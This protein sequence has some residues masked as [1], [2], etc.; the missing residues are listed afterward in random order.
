MNNL[1]IQ[2]IFVRITGTTL[3]CALAVI[4]LTTLGC[5]KQSEDDT[6]PAQMVVPIKAFLPPLQIEFYPPPGWSAVSR[7]D[8]ENFKQMLANSKLSQGFYP[9]TLLTMLVDSA[10]RGMM[11]VSSLDTQGED[12][13]GVI[14]HNLE[15]FLS[16]EGVLDRN[17]VTRNNP[18]VE[19]IPMYQYIL[20]SATAINHKIIARTPDGKIFYFEYVY[21]ATRADAIRPF[22]NSSIA[23]FKPAPRLSDT[24]LTP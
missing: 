14:Q 16:D 22:V 15:V 9:V 19:G 5:E 2:K 18:L 3:L 6:A 11:E 13:L 10:S 8:F 4:V 20:E 1:H 21:P 24:S 7:R 17:K 12:D 23:S